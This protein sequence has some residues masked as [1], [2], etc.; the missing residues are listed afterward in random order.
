MLAQDPASKQLV[1]MLGD[2]LG[3]LTNMVKAFAERLQEQQQAQAQQ[4]GGLDPA[5]ASKV[6]ANQILAQ[7]KAENSKQSH[8][9]KTAQKQISFE[10]SNVAKREAV[11]N[12]HGSAD[13]ADEDRLPETAWRIAVGTGQEKGPASSAGNCRS[14][15]MKKAREP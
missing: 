12:R 11:S 4:G 7:Q 10:Q 3:N 5:T 2:E 1:K 13:S 8:A 14:R 15:K 9:Q 6:Q